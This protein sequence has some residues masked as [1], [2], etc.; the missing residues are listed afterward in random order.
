MI[1][2]NIK[3]IA[4]YAAPNQLENLFLENGFD[5]DMRFKYDMLSCSM[6]CEEISYVVRKFS[7]IMLMSLNVEC[8]K[9]DV[10]MMDM[11]GQVGM[12]KCA[13]IKGLYVAGDYLLK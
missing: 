4:S 1:S 2:N 5:F 13:Y 3:I 6:K 11:L 12:D 7:N 10:N 9:H 8:E